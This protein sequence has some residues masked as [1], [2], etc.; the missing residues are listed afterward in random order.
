MCPDCSLYLGAS[1]AYLS[2]VP[3]MHF[4]FVLRLRRG[5][6]RDANEQMNCEKDLA[7]TTSSDKKTRT[8]RRTRT[9]TEH[10]TEHKKTMCTVLRASLLRFAASASFP[11]H[12]KGAR[13]MHFRASIAAHS[14]IT[15]GPC[16]TARRIWPQWTVD[17][18]AWPLG[19]NLFALQRTTALSRGSW[20]GETQRHMA[21]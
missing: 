9:R 6:P 4:G 1:K 18:S 16:M 20:E 14:A 7:V 10:A 21:S 11:L 13:T 15:K 5:R 8:A 12:R 17:Y 3:P 2:R 19:G